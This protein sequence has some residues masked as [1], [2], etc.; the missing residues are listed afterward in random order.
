MA[1]KKLTDEE[2]KAAEES[3]KKENEQIINDVKEAFALVEDE[4][5]LKLGKKIDSYDMDYL[6]ALNLIFD[7]FSKGDFEFRKVTRWE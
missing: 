7:K 2:K 1:R 6:T 5:I 3:R 4:A